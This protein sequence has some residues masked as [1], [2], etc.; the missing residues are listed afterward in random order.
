[1]GNRVWAP[2]LGRPGA[3]HVQSRS[4][5]VVHESLSLL[6]A[7]SGERR[8]RCRPVPLKPL[9]SREGFCDLSGSRIR[10]ERLPARLVR[11]SGSARAY[12]SDIYTAVEHISTREIT[13]LT[14]YLPSLSTCFYPPCGGRLRYPIFFGQ[15]HDAACHSPEA[16][17][18]VTREMWIN[19]ETVKV[20]LPNL[21]ANG[22]TTIG[23]R[24]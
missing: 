21:A 14:R 7:S 15:G 5:V 12:K 18:G 24:H 10:Q 6:L 22:S 3:R 13:C 23:C 4:R 9:T 16:R 19:P 8:L 17:M 20:L 11:L 1:M 2:S